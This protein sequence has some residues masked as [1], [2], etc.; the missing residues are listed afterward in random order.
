MLLG[1]LSLSAFAG[2]GDVTMDGYPSWGERDVHI[3]TNTVRV[4]PHAF[5]GEGATV[6]RECDIDDFVGDEDTPK[7]PLHYE[8]DLNESGRFHSQDMYDND[9]FDHTSYDGTSFAERVARFYMESGFVGENIALGYPSAESVVLDGWMCS[10]GHRANIM[11]GD[12]NELGVG[13]VTLY[14]TQN[15]GAGLVDTASPIAMGN[16][17]PQ[18]PIGEVE[19]MVDF[20]GFEPDTLDVI[21]NGSPLPVVLTYGV[22]HQG[23]YTAARTGLEELDC[24]EYYFRWTHDDERGTFPEEGSYMYGTECTSELMWR[25]SQITPEDERP[26]PE[27]ENDA[28]ILQ[29]QAQDDL[30]DS[31]VDVVGCACSVYGPQNIRGGGMFALLGVLIGWRRRR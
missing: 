10:A 6:A 8:F 30:D 14:Y 19:F 25:E 5:F 4:D 13:V 26:P 21:I 28:N 11:N 1:L 2:Y 15:F 9:F 22:A 31:D 24:Y 18:I 7:A 17:L 20:Q 29:D 27:F 16:H 3:W 12:Y 23:I